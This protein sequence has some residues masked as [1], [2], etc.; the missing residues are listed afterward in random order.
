MTGF[1]EELSEVIRHVIIR[2]AS[3][4]PPPSRIGSVS[5]DYTARALARY[6][7]IHSPERPTHMG[8]CAPALSVRVAAIVPTLKTRRSI[9]AVTHD[10]PVFINQKI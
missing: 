4:D 8:A 9:D 6:A 5:G 3:I 10:N 2:P 1:F 7:A